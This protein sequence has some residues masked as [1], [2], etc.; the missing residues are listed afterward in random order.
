MVYI[1][2]STDTYSWTWKENQYF[3]NFLNS[4]ITFRFT[5]LFT[6]SFS[7]TMLGFFFLQN[8]AGVRTCFT[9]FDRGCMI[10]PAR[11]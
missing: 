1:F 8:L 7:V 3:L 2:L 6:L 11:A 5:A 10:V 9:R 4:D